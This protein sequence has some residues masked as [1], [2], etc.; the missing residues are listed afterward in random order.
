MDSLVG[1]LAPR[2]QLWLR[3]LTQTRSR[4]VAVSFN[5]LSRRVIF[6]SGSTLFFATSL[7]ADHLLWIF[8]FLGHKTI[9]GL[10]DPALTTIDLGWRQLPSQVVRQ[11]FLGSRNCT[12]HDRIDIFS[13]FF[14]L[15][16]DF[17]RDFDYFILYLPLFSF[18]F[19]FLF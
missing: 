3:L 18:F 14:V 6:V 7:I 8:I 17:G 4:F 15:L 13:L 12:S 19:L 11:I 5:D 10:G 2:K 16:A 9:L 1:I